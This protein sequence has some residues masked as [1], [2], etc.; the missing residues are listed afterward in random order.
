MTRRISGPET[1]FRQM[2]PNSPRADFWRIKYNCRLAIIR[3]FSFSAGK[4]GLRPRRRTIDYGRSSIVRTSSA[5]HRL[6]SNNRV[7]PRLAFPGGHFPE[8]GKK[9]TCFFLA[10]R[11]PRSASFQSPIRYSKSEMLFRLSNQTI[12]TKNSARS[13]AKWHRMDGSEPSGVGRN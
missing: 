5:V 7:F 3:F 6:L 9:Q 1:V 11:A 10:L 2:R 4:N 12:L 13:R 8:A